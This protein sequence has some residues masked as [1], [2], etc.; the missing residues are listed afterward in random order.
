MVSKNNENIVTPLDNLLRKEAPL[1]ILK[2]PRHTTLVCEIELNEVDAILVV[3]A[4]Q[5]PSDD[6]ECRYNN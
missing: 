5:R 6:Q 4:L 2:I 1:E 3:E